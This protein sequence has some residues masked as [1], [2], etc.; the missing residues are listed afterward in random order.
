MLYNMKDLL[1]TAMKYNFAVP[2]FNVSDYSMMKGLLEL[3]EDLNAPVIFEIHPD[4]LKHTGP[5]FVTSIK[6]KVSKIKIPV[7]IH[8]DHG[9]DFSQV[10]Q[11]I[12]AGFTSVMIDGSSLPFEENIAICRK[13]V[14]A[15]HAVDVSV[16]GELG[17]IGTTNDKQAEAGTDQIIYTNPEDAKVFVEKTKVDT[18]AVAIGTCHG[19]YPEGFTPK[20]K[21]D[22]LS[23]IRAKVDVPLVLHGGSNNPDEEISEA[24]ARGINKINISSDIKTAYFV[25]MREVLEDKTLREPFSIHPDCVDAMKKVAAHKLELLQ[26]TGKASLY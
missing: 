13:V 25:K 26:T 19:L 3:A 14:E 6:E 23:D 21:Q 10:M 22:L 24:V 8:L 4:E 5:E 15:A 16:E 11:A 1:R 12:R 18:L 20:L 9:A 7:C 17:T 2:A